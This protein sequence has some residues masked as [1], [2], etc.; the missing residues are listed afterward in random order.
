MR[1]KL[2]IIAGFIAL[3]VLSRPVTSAT[4]FH[5]TGTLVLD[6]RFAFYNA[7]IEE[8]YYFLVFDNTG[9]LTD[10]F[11]RND[12]YV[13]F[14]LE[15][16]VDGMDEVNGQKSVPK[17]KYEIVTFDFELPG[18]YVTS[19]EFHMY[20]SEDLCSFI[21]DYEGLA[22]YFELIGSI[23]VEQQQTILI[24]VA[25]TSGGIIILLAIN[26]VLVRNRIYF[27]LARKF[28]ERKNKKAGRRY[29]NIG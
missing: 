2:A 29:K 20:A 17:G 27:K 6:R 13:I 23:N 15:F 14:F 28:R 4:T 10:N 24:A 1:T 18:I 8:G 5:V 11:D 22:A 26:T 16:S 19:V 21:A 12:S 25:S 7:I 9:F 3:V